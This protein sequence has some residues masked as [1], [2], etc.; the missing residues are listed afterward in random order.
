MTALQ[1]D[2]AEQAGL[3]AGQDDAFLERS[4]SRMTWSRIIGSLFIAGFLVYGIGAAV[5]ASI[6]GEPGFISTIAEKE[7]LLIAGVLLMLLNVGVDIGKGVLFFPIVESYSKRTALVYFGAVTAQAVLL[8][9]G[10]ILILMLIPLGGAA[11]LSSQSWAQGA[12]DALVHGNTMAY[13]IGQATLSFGGLFLSL[14]LFRT[15]LIPRA[16]AGLGVFGYIVHCAGSL[17]ELFGLGV[18]VYLL[19]PGAAFELGIAFWLI[20]K[21]F[22]TVAYA[23]AFSRSSVEP[24]GSAS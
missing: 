16:L 4:P 12:A 17:A 9:I 22:S 20:F 7:T 11:D 24:I 23:K 3:A 5:V 2:I 15:Q 18:G 8:A 1:V 21:G 19:I 6:V 13:N 14:L 10:G